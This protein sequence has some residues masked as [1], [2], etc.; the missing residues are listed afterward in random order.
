MASV[1]GY[2]PIN[3]LTGRPIP[4]GIYGDP[5]QS[6]I[7]GADEV[8]RGCL[9]GPVMVG[10]VLVPRDLAPLAGITDSKKLSPKRRFELAHEL[11]MHHQVQWSVSSVPADV[12]D[13]QGIMEALRQCFTNAVQALL[14]KQPDALVL[15]DGL[16]LKGLPFEADFLVKGD[17]NNWVI[18][19]ASIVAKVTR[20]KQMEVA[21]RSHPAYG[22]E[23]NKGYGTANHVAAIKEHG[24]CELHRASF[25]KA[26]VPKPV[27]VLDGLFG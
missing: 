25:C 13:K 2:P 22:W 7:I 5:N 9:A 1:C 8:G 10:A 18:G 27:N 11:D 24:L 14:I 20:D 17:L 26:F 21:A 16:P 6:W 15:I 3:P 19:A 12:I 23:I 4:P